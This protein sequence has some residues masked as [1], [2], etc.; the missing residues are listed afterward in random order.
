MYGIVLASID[1][2]IRNRL[3]RGISPLIPLN[4]KVD[5]LK[6]DNIVSVRFSDEELDMA[7]RK[8]KQAGMSFTVFIRAAVTGAKIKEAPPADFY[9][10]IREVRKVGT[11]LNQ[12]AA[13]ANSLGF[14]D[15]LLL[16]D[17]LER[18][19]KTEA[20]LWDTFRNGG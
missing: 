7:K 15:A 3:V 9:E 18:N 13:K 19:H 16:K 12:L 8:A 4:R 11:N 17:A 14:I 5:R 10:L 20:M 2:V 6:K 1:F